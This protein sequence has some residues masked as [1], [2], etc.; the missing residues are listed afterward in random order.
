MQPISTPWHFI[1]NP[2][3][4]G[5]KGR[6]RWRKLLPRLR[7]AI[8]NMTFAISTDHTALGALARD[9]VS[10]GKTHLVGVGGDGTHHHIL[11]GL[12]AS[13]KLSSVVYAP[14]ALGSGND[15]A[16]SLGTP[17]DFTA[18][19]AYLGNGRERT[20]LVGHI[21]FVKTG[22]VHYFLNVAGFAYDAEIV[23]IAREERIRHQWMYP[24]LALSYLSEYVAPTVLV[25][26]Q[27]GTGG[28]SDSPELSRDDR[29]IPVHTINVGV[30]RYSGGGMQ[31]VPHADLFGD[32]LA[33]TVAEKMPRWKVMANSWR[34]YAGSIGVVSGVTISHVDA[35]EL[36]PTA[37]TLECE[38]DGEWL[39]KG[40]VVISRCAERLRVLTKVEGILPELP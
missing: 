20:Q 15:W 34:F 37:G 33:L 9:A 4:A 25:S 11:N 3:A 22:A 10:L 35:V 29:A 38:A 28:A 1:L 40:P 12:V 27:P 2:A 31:F 7:A 30:G 8:P 39:G 26:P 23:R 6:L 21:E 19:L 24:I 16:R 17:T 14:L 5:G 36:I 18:W 32:R 13:G